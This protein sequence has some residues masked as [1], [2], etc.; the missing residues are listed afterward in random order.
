MASAKGLRAPILPT[1]LTTTVKIQKSEVN[2]YSKCRE[3]EKVELTRESS[4][5]CE[6]LEK[7]RFF[8]L[9]FERLKCALHVGLCSG[10]GSFF[11]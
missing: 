9:K 5:Y 10:H 11:L 8:N 1:P 6:M 2:A 4:Y 7:P 3:A